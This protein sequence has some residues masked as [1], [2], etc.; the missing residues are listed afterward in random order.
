MRIGQD[1]TLEV[2]SVKTRSLETDKGVGGKVAMSK[3]IS[4]AV[5][6]RIINYHLPLHNLNNSAA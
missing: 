5:L 6:L 1:F 2:S 3:P 4:P